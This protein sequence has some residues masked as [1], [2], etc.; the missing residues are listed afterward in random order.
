MGTPAREPLHRPSA[1]RH[2]MLDG[3]GDLG[4]APRDLHRAQLRFHRPPHRRGKLRVRAGAALG[5]A[6][7]L[8]PS[9]LAVTIRLRSLER[10][11]H[12]LMTNTDL[13]VLFA[14]RNEAVTCVE[15]LRIAPRIEAYMLEAR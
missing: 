4:G 9:G 13:D 8:T 10:A 14:A 3:P 2:A 15:R 5:A 7:T 11:F 12:P 1:L 6:L